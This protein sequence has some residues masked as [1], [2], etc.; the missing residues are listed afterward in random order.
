MTQIATAPLLL[1]VPANSPAKNLA[2][3][4]QLLVVSKGT[5]SCGSWGAGS[6][7][8]LACANMGVSL[9]SSF[10]H[11][12]YKGE[13]PMLQDAVR[14]AVNSPELKARLEALGM[15]GVGNIPEEFR[16]R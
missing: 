3:L 6:Y 16:Q 11:I 1:L 10:A 2:E 14:Q 12:P 15:V 9:N 7:P 13:A 5:A 8:H 4:R